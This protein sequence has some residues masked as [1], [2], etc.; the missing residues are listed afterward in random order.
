MESGPPSVQADSLLS[1][2][3]GKNTLGNFKTNGS[4]TSKWF[5]AREDGMRHNDNQQNL[6][7][8]V[9]RNWEKI[10]LSWPLLKYSCPCFTE[11][12]V[13]VCIEKHF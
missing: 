13:K 10:H 12:E 2:P 7:N 8:T 11:E 9:R 4:Q 6:N 5:S 3:P 1:E